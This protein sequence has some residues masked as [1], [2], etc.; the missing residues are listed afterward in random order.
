MNTEQQLQGLVV[1]TI[2]IGFFLVM[3]I[4]LFLLVWSGKIDLGAWFGGKKC[5][6]C[7]GRR[8]GKC[9]ARCGYRQPED[10]LG[11]R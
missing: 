10:W 3:P 7:G 6:R 9:C 8:V 11:D 1:L 2:V 5:P 4:F